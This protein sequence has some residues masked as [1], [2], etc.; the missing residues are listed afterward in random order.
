MYL[1]QQKIELTSND[2]LC[3]AL[4]SLA[5]TYAANTDECIKQIIFTHVRIALDTIIMTGNS[6]YS[7][8]NEIVNNL[9][10]SF[11]ENHSMPNYQDN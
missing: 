9:T 4:V 3:A 11:L 1:H 7:V 2:V 6:D 5:S 8:I 10:V